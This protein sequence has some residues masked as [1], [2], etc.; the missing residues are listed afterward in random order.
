MHLS[1]FVSTNQFLPR[2]NSISLDKTD[3]NEAVIPCTV[4]LIV[5]EPKPFCNLAQGK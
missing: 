5:Q 1:S 4:T 2:I 3:G